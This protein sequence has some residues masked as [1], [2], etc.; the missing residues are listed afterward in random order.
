MMYLTQVDEDMQ[1]YW[2]CGLGMRLVVQVHIKCAYEFYICTY[3]CTQAPQERI[4]GRRIVQ[5]GDKVKNEADK[6]YYI[7][8]LDSL[9]QLS[10]M[11]LV[12]DHVSLPLCAS[13][14]IH[15]SSWDSVS[16]VKYTYTCLCTRIHTHT[17]THM[18]HTRHQTHTLM[19]VHIIRT[20]T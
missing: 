8:I 1:P 2:L 14:Y 19:Y 18:G 7:P 5:K 11:E 12:R 10:K 3:M 13:M 4:L 16:M 15:S 17:H 6:C 9:Q 20:C